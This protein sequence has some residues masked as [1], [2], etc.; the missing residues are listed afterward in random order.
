MDNPRDFLTKPSDFNDVSRGT[1]IPHTLQGDALIQARLT[2]ETWTLEIVG[3]GKAEV[4]KPRKLADNTPIDMP[5]LLALG[6]THGVRFLKAMQCNNIA[7]PL[8]QGLWE[9]VPL[10]EVL[11]LAGKI[12]N[13]RRVEY[14]GFHNN[15]PKQMFRSTLAMNQVLDTPPDALP[16]FLAYKLNGEPIPLERGGPVRMLIPWAH[17]FKS[18]KWLQNIVLTDAYQ[19]SD[20]YALANNDPESYLKT[21]AYI[22]DLEPR[23]FPAG[24]PIVIRGTAMVGWPGLER[25]ESWLR[26]ETGTHG[27]IADNDSAWKTATWQP[28]TIEP[29]PTDWSASLPKGNQPKDIHGFGLDNKPKEWPMRFSIALWQT[30]LEGLKPGGYEFRVRTIDKNHFAQPE[31]RPGQKSGR[32]AIQC[33][34]F[35]VMG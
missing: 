13:V 28:C 34:Q 21:A 8:G 27:V 14:W 30:T 11:H 7:Q 10:R 9:G 2:P 35:I 15:D 4:E 3:E 22:D 20:T 1:P 26:P 24:K 19:A 25:V 12:G 23:T 29:P 17:G 6:E 18:V 5:T 32:N 33:K 31:P 16:P